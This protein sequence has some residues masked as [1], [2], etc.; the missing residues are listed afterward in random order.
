MKK[1]FHD[2]KIQAVLC[3]MLSVAIVAGLCLPG[4]ALQ[5]KELQ[6]P[7]GGEIQDINVLLMG[8]GENGSSGGMNSDEEDESEEGENGTSGGGNNGS[9]KGES[10]SSTAKPKEEQPEEKQE[11]T[12]S[13]EQ[14]T[15]DGDEGQEEGNIGEEG[16]DI[17]QLDV[18]MVMAWYKYG[19]ERRTIVCG[20]S[21]VVSK[22]INTAQLID[23]QL[24]YEFF[25]AGED[26]DKIEITAVSV[27]V[28]DGLFDEVSDEGEM[29][30]QLHDANGERDYTFLVEAVYRTKNDKGGEIEQPVTFTYVLRCSY[31]LDLEMQLSWTEEDGSGASLICTAN[32]SAARTVQSHELKEGVFRYDVQL[33]GTMAEDAEIIRAEYSTASGQA[34]ALDKESGSMVLRPAAGSDRETYYLTYEV[35][36]GENNPVVFY[37]FTIVYVDALDLQLAFTWLEKGTTPRLLVCQP[38]SSVSANVKNNQLSAGAIKYE[39]ELTGKDSETA[40]ILNI[41]YVSDSSG[42]GKLSESGAIPASLPEGSSFNTYTVQVLALA[43]GR[44]VK[45]E[46]K[47][48]FFSD[49]RLEM[50]YSVLENGVS[51]DRM[52]LC[53]NGKSVTA[54]EIYDDQLTEGVLA[55]SMSIADGEDSGVV[56]ESVSCYQSGSSKTVS[57]D[58]SDSIVLLLAGGQTGENNFTVLAKDSGGGEYRFRINIPYKH[59][60]QNTIKISTN[61]VDGQVVINETET[62]LSVT[63]WSEDANGKVVSS[64][65]ANGVDTKLIVTLDGEQLSY[66]SSSGASSEYIICPKNP[67]TGDTN[68]HSLHVYAEDAFGNYGEL[69]VSLQGQRNQAGQKKGTATIYVDLSVLGLGIVGSVDYEILV[70]EPISYAIAKA[71]LGMDTGD[72]FGSVENPLGWNGRYGGT[73]DDGFYLKSLTPGLSA[74]ALEGSSWNQYGSTEEEILQAIDDRFGRGTGLATLWRCIYRNGLNKSSGSD[75]SF[76]EFDFSSGSGWVYSI[77][78]SYYPGQSMCEYSLEDGDVLTLRYT[79]AYGW[80]IGGGTSGYGN[81]AGYCVTAINGS[82]DIN[83]QMEEVV[84]E[85]GVVTYVCR[86]CGLQE[87]CTHAGAA[88]M[89]RGDGT[90]STFCPDCQTYMG[91]SADHIWEA[92]VENHICSVCGAEEI[93]NWQEIEGSNTA[94][95]LN[96]GVVTLSCIHCGTTTEQAS[97]PKG[98]S[99]NDRWNHTATEH[100]QKCSVCGETIGESVGAHDYLYS[101]GDEDW[102]CSICEA[103]HDWDYCGNRSLEIRSADCTEIIY[104]CPDCGIELRAEGEFPD[105]HTY[106]D[107]SCLLCGAADPNYQ[108]PEEPDEPEDSEEIPPEE[109]EE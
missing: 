40:R 15:G 77:D 37:H 39:M 63:A 6:N 70:D 10:G 71:I 82:F 105:Y 29:G 107:G 52:L 45:F 38:D 34:G 99:L 98:H 97:P 92:G 57:L 61:M 96:E 81:T 67:L 55:Y 3:V 24:E 72:T 78:G 21:D 32:N 19:K 30:I 62:N 80:D 68:T 66:V 109:N 91:D 43:G 56:I 102:Y 75:G 50:R 4:F 48:R 47:L 90:H 51:A 83:H 88:P 60:G 27:K 8:D 84:D 94:T 25:T 11:E 31:M 49:V 54:E 12:E 59:R 7:I 58:A 86:C 76:G 53:E 64:I 69:T 65:P 14:S 28:G 103:G 36:C 89:N 41:S 20:P 26:G 74:D 1:L 35:Q 16:G 5:T 9:G 106:E 87:G 79:L 104:F 101:A 2:K 44:Q 85:N 46:V 100:Y 18:A 22:R 17:S 95:C 108:P 33:L 23:G 13:E 73:L 93:H 42:G